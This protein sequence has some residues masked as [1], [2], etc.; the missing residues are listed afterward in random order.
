MNYP[1][2][3]NKT[4]EFFIIVCIFI[5]FN[6]PWNHMI[7]QAISRYFKNMDKLNT[8]FV[9]IMLMINWISSATNDR[10][11]TFFSALEAQKVTLQLSIY[12][13]FYIFIPISRYFKNTDKLNTVFVEIM[14]MI[15]WIS[16]ATNDRNR[17]FLVR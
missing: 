16:S 2:N 15:N 14:L 11:R 12:F 13:D 3:T 9:E 7:L 17:T 4:S 6:S 5:E 1:I 10:N 8:V